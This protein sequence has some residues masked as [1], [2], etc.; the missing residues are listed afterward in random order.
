MREISNTIFPRAGRAKAETSGKPQA[1]GARI[2]RERYDDLAGASVLRRAGKAADDGAARG[3]MGAPL[4]SARRRS[5][6][7]QGIGDRLRDMY[8]S[9]VDEPIPARLVELLD[10]LEAGRTH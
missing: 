2:A 6:A 8:Q 1:P 7:G 9:V 4:L 5:R 3:V 10:R